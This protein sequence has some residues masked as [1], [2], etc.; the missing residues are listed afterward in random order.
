MK[1]HAC[2]GLWVGLLFAGL[3]AWTIPVSLA[4]TA[5]DASHLE[6]QG[7]W[8]GALGMYQALYQTQ[9]RD[10]AVVINL[11]RLT[12]WQGNWDKSQ[13]YYQEAQKLAISPEE[14]MWADFGLGEIMG[15]EGRLDEAKALY[16]PWISEAAD[17]PEPRYRM[18]QLELWQNHMGKAK[19]LFEEN[20][21]QFPAHT[22]TRLALAELWAAKGQYQKSLAMYDDLMHVENDNPQVWVG[23]IKTYEWHGDLLKAQTLLN[24]ADKRFPGNQAINN[25]SAEIAALVNRQPYIA[26][27]EK[28][29][30][31]H[32]ANP[33]LVGYTPKV[34]LQSIYTGHTE[35]GTVDEKLIFN[36][37]NN[38]LTVYPTKSGFAQWFTST[39]SSRAM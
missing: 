20:L 30:V 1:K 31:N 7:D 32:W 26:R 4:A 2:R 28:V 8:Q 16:K 36:K 17:N 23:K 3:L 27:D 24:E 15:W 10:Y 14:K 35:T 22:P 6:N 9:P 33:D 34:T 12:G 21:K 38:M 5:E 18:G 25:Q 11:A 13:Q 19:A 37:F 29:L 39:F